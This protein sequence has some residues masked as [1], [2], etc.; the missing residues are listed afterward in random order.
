MYLGLRHAELKA[1]LPERSEIYPPKNSNAPDWFIATNASIETL[2]ESLRRSVFVKGIYEIIAGPTHSWES[3][4][5]EISRNSHKFQNILEEN[6]RNSFEFRKIPEDFSRNFPTKNNG[7]AIRIT[8]IGSRVF[9]TQSAR[10]IAIESVLKSL[11]YRGAIN[12]TH[13]SLRFTI[14]TV[15]VSDSPKQN[16][17]VST[18]LGQPAQVSDSPAGL[19]AHVSDSPGLSAHV[20]DSPGLSKHVSDSTELKSEKGMNSNNGPKS[21]EK[22]K[23]LPEGI[24]LREGKKVLEEKQKTLEKSE[25]YLEKS[26]NYLKKGKIY[27][28]DFREYENGLCCYF[29]REILPKPSEISHCL[30]KLNLTTRR[31]TGPTCMD[32]PLA[33]VMCN[34]AKVGKGDFVFDP[35]VGTGSILLAAAEFGAYTFGMDASAS[36]IGHYTSPTP[37]LLSNFRDYSLPT[38]MGII[39]GS[40]HSPPFRSGNLFDAIICDPPYGI[41]ESIRFPEIDS[42]P[43]TKLIEKKGSLGAMLNYLLTL[44]A[45]TLREGGSLVFWVPWP[46]SGVRTDEPSVPTHPGLQHI[47]ALYQPLTSKWGRKLLVYRKRP[48]SGREGLINMSSDCKGSGNWWEELRDIV[49]NKKSSGGAMSWG[50]SKKV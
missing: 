13:P 21:E 49:L 36:T 18:G 38:P 15:H 32:T 4:R 25:N 14:L 9:Q 12:L 31:F 28:R 46:S 34:L 19:S 42:G 45:S 7:I 1:L 50:R 11:D 2:R 41:K 37:S 44:A 10:T 35:F 39:R 3:L 27:P 47:H 5:T 43:Q 26:E 16:V 8:S 30:Q 48:F 40:I 23:K 33:F 24:S 17:H 6:S 29:L 20:S 22:E